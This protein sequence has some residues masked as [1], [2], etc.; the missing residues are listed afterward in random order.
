[1]SDKIIGIDLGSTN[2]CVAIMEG[3]QPTVIINDEGSRTTP[4]VIGLGGG[5]R[6]VGASAKR[7]QV[8]QPKETV[9]LIK[10]FMGATYE[11][12]KEA[13][14]HVKYDVVNDGGFP[15]VD[16]EGKKYSP[17]EL[18]SMIIGK[19]KCIAE[20]YCGTTIDKAVITVPAFFND[21]ARQATKTAGEMAGLKVE[22]IIA[23][24]TAAILS[25]NI[26]MEKGGKYM[27][28]DFG[29]ATLDNSV[30]DISDGVVE[31]KATNGDIYCGG[32]DI[33]KIVADYLIK[34][35]KDKEG[36]DLS[37]DAMAYSRVYEA[38]EKAK[39]DLSNM[40]QTEINLPYIT[41]GESG[42]KHLI[43][44]L[45]KAT[46]ERLI[47]PVVNKVITCAKNAL[48]EAK[49]TASDLDGILLV[50]GSCRIPLVQERLT[51]EFGVELLHTSNLDECVATGAAVQGGI[52]AGDGKSDVILLD[53]TPLRYGIETLGG[54]M[55]TLVDA[56]TTIPVKKSQIF[57][58]AED[59]QPAVT[60]NVLQGL[61]PMAKDNKSVGLFTLDGIIPARKGIPQIEV[62]FDI[63]VNGILSV[64]AVDKGT[65]KEQ[66][67]TIETKS[68][69]SDEDIER[70]KAEAEAHAE[71]DKKAKAH[72]DDANKCESMIWQ[73]EKQMEDENFKD[74]I[75]EEDKSKFNASIE[76]LKEMQKADDYAGLEDVEKDINS[77][78]QEIATKMYSSINTGN[79]MDDLQK[80]MFGD[81]VGTEDNP[82]DVR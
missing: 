19:M 32:S 38:A 46:F 16:I 67:I 3:G 10:R 49:M 37:F 6:I 57:S 28:T 74:K 15:K 51:K 56:N 48:R 26:N 69:V 68:G 41:M 42:P 79:P 65:N 8:T 7:K 40:S 64:S 54:V 20:T 71:E 18:S 80:G 53:V 11:E 61:R 50:G 45:N 36:V 35:F 78:W 58:T 55:T 25:S 21:A 82:Q 60:I 34:E 59:N 5:E 81:N 76:K 47:E 2:S 73:T 13:R 23:E 52:I 30:A 44:T 39:C 17:E 9:I 4:S 27:V 75:T 70:I 62:T 72:A 14:N 33:D 66:H 63:D 22:R 77:V 1:M 31:I 24:P 43:T 29:G 12:S